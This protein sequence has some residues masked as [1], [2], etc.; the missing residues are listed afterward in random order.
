MQQNPEFLADRILH[1]LSAPDRTAPPSEAVVGLSI[2]AAYDI[3]RRVRAGLGRRRVG[4]KVGFTNRSLWE[5]YNVDRPIWGEVYD[6]GLFTPDNPIPLAPYMEPRIEPEIVL[7]LAR[8]PEPGMDRAALR[9]CID[10][11]APGFEI[12]QSI[13]QGWSFTVADTIAAQGLHGALVLGERQRATAEMLDGLPSVPLD[14]T[15]DGAHVENGIGANALGGPVSV[16]AHLVDVL[17]DKDALEGGELVTTGTLTDA[18][19]VQ[20]GEIWTARYGGVIGQGLE[21]RFV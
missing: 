3:A 19:S 14:L 18:W 17:G 7:G 11:V 4:R 15:R 16:L 5:R 8:A 13:Y 6:E 9:D 12:V 10:W 21:V 1:A 20:P 2:S